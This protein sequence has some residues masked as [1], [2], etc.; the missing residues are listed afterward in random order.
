MASSF[1]AAMSKLAVLGHNRNALIDCSDVVPAPSTAAVKSASFPATKGPADL[2]LS[3]NSTR[4]PTLT[5]D[6]E[7]CF[8]AG[9]SPGGG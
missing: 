8:R 5:S 9:S 2:Q 6:R 7:Y 1:K 3:C 4:F